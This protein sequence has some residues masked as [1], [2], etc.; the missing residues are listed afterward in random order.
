VCGQSFAGS[1]MKD[2]EPV[3]ERYCTRLLEAIE[4][5]A[6]EKGMVDMNDWFNRFSFDVRSHLKV[7]PR[8]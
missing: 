8:S 7:K 5:V 4:V 2:F 3:L 6:N 1:S